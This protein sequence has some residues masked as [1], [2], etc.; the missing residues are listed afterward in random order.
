MPGGC[1][2]ACIRWPFGVRDLFHVAA[3]Q[4]VHY[5]AGPYLS[6][7]LLRGDFWVIAA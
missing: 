7:I 5:F 1:T 4:G 3:F 2:C 6:P